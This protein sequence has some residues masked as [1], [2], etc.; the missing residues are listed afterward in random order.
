MGSFWFPPQHSRPIG[1]LCGVGRL[2][3][4]LGWMM[5]LRRIAFAG[6]SKHCLVYDPTGR[7]RTG[8]RAR[9]PNST[10]TLTPHRSLLAGPHTSR[11]SPRSYAN[12][13]GPAASSLQ[14]P[15]RR[16]LS[17]RN[18]PSARSTRRNRSHSRAS[19][20][21]L[22]PAC[23]G[24]PDPAS[25]VSCSIADVLDSLHACGLTLHRRPSAPPVEGGPQPPCVTSASC[26][27]RATVCRERSDWCPYA[28]LPRRW[29]SP[30]VSSLPPPHAVYP[31]VPRL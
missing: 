1:V 5:P 27:R 15:I 19:R 9:I 18:G 4:P 17:L 20:L 11:G 22:V 6:A 8:R 21:R 10:R 29:A 28:L 14:Q 26:G 13:Y 16:T 7:I 25:Q 31:S 23:R 12:D 3:A 24:R 2:R 30:P